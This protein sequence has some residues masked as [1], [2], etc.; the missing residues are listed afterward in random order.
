MAEIEY[1]L[2]IDDKEY[3]S[4]KYSTI[5]LEGNRFYIFK[6]R[7]GL[8]GKERVKF[9]DKDLQINRLTGECY[10]IKNSKLT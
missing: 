6:R 9:E 10:L 8:F 5:D 2:I 7:K 4:E 1:K 3:K